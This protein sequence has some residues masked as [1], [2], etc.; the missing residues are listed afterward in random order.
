[1]RSKFVR[2]YSLV[3]QVYFK[4]DKVRHR[5]KFAILQEGQTYDPINYQDSEGVSD[6]DMEALDVIDKS[7]I[8]E[9]AV[10]HKN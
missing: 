6:E 8:D 4:E 10:I 9:R 1:M 3:N 7:I 5:K 2:D